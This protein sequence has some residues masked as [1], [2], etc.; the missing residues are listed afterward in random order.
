MA[1]MLPLPQSPPWVI[2]L[3]G[4]LVLRQDFTMYVVQPGL[5]LKM[6]PML[7][8]SQQSSCLG[9]TR[10]SLPGKEPSPGGHSQVPNCIFVLYFTRARPNHLASLQTSNAVGANWHTQCLYWKW[11]QGSAQYFCSESLLKPVSATA[12]SPTTLGLDGHCQ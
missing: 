1:Q 7:A 8:N 3:F 9:A 6:Q 12:V 10:S 4:W 2:F 5:E 11:H